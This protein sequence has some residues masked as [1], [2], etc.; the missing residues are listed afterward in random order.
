MFDLYIHTIPNTNYFGK[1]YAYKIDIILRKT[2]K[3][4]INFE[5]LI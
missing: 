3:K 4:M 1:R 2:G 5:I